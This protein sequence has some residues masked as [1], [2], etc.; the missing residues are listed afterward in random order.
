MAALLE[1]QNQEEIIN[2]ENQIVGCLTKKGV[3]QND[4]SAVLKNGKL[5]FPSTGLYYTTNEKEKKGGK[6]YVALYLP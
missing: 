2:Q 5:S 4:L 1:M 3:S 6:S